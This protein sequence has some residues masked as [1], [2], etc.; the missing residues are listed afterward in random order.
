ML[1][2]Y[3]IGI[4]AADKMV[5]KTGKRIDPLSENV[6]YRKTSWFF[7]NKLTLDP[8]TA[9][10]SVSLSATRKFRMN[11]QQGVQGNS[12]KF[13]GFHIDQR[14]MFPEHSDY[15]VISM[16]RFSGLCQRY[17]KSTY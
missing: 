15:V 17:P 3:L 4:L 2:R 8:G 13:L 12:C 5:I 9:K 16:Y 14:L 10:K 6:V 11:R 1:Q 7:L